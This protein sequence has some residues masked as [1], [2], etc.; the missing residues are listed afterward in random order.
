[1]LL[2]LKKFNALGHYAEFEFNFIQPL[3]I[4]C[5]GTCVMLWRRYVC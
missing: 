5:I 2:V 1:L 3:I 4:F